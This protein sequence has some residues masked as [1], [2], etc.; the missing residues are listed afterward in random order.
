M[1]NTKTTV[2]Y[3]RHGESEGNVAG[4]ASGSE[5]DCDLTDEGRRQAKEAGRKLRDKK[6]DLIVC[7]PMK[8]TVETAELI[9]KELGYEP[10]RIVKRP[11]FIERAMGYYSGRPHAE[12]REAV[13]NGAVHESL[14]TTKAMLDRVT[15]GLS[16]LKKQPAKNV[17]L[18][19]HGG[20]GRAIKAFSQSLNHEDMYKIEGF[21]NTEIYEFSL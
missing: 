14:E 13:M 2:Y 3:V 10:T 1:T 12:Y 17:V 4:V 21:G 16:W 19:S 5:H 15:S 11:E 7:S 6:V 9:A 18:V 20:T 8:R